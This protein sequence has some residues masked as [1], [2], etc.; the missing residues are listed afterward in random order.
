[1]A[2][3]ILQEDLDERQILSQLGMRLKERRI[4][5]DLTIA[6]LAV[7]ANV[8]ESLISQLER[9]IGNP[10]F[11]TLVKLAQALEIETNELFS[12]GDPSAAIVIHPDQRTKLKIPGRGVMSESLV[13]DAHFN[14]SA[15]CSEYEPCS[16]EE[17]PYNHKGGET[18]FVLEGCFEF[19]YGKRTYQLNK[20]DT[21]N[22]RGEIP[23]WGRNP[24]DK[25][26]KLI[27]IIE[28]K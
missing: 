5:L 15:L 24:G 25:L 9:G 26:A 7:R 23:H 16:K 21:I 28:E 13:P 6:D 20:G 22:F 17:Q 3:P 18:L 2:D 12:S 14:F 19:H 4:A 27:M 1:M 10:A 8:S 11:L